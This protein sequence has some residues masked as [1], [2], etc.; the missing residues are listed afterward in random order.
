MLTTAQLKQAVKISE[1]LDAL[2]S[3]LA[4]IMGGSSGSDKNVKAAKEPKAP[5]AKKAKNTMSPEGREKIA[6]AQRKRWAKQK[7]AAKK[8][9]AKKDADKKEA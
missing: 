7:K 9:A 5:K 6:A 1:K 8:E 4:S 2:K 3:E